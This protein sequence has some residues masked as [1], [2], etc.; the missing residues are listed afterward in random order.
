M[1]SGSFR[2]R[3]P[4]SRR[5][6][7]ESTAD[8]GG[9]LWL[10]CKNWCQHERTALNPTRADSQV[11]T[12]VLS[13]CS[14][15][16]KGKTGHLYRFQTSAIVNISATRNQYASRKTTDTQEERTRQKD[17]GQPGGL[18]PCPLRCST[19]P[20]SETASKPN[21]VVNLITGFSATDDVSLN[22]SPTVSPT[23]RRRVQRRAL[24]LQLGL[25]DLLRVVPRAA[26]VRHEDRLVEPEERDRRSGSR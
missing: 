1:K 13:K 3:F 18:P 20:P 24:H 25:D 21:S 2:T 22:G 7:P 23:D 4:H 16:C 8:K 9:R 11:Q 15:G 26:G 17:G 10:T 19:E 12:P 14:P 6:G 5:V